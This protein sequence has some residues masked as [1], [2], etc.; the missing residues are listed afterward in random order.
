MEEEG[1]VEEERGEENDGIDAD[2]VRKSPTAAMAVNCLML[3][4]HKRCRLWPG[5]VWCR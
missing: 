5:P 2:M 4:L 3:R 1:G